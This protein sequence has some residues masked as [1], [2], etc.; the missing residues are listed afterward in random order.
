LEGFSFPETLGRWTDGRFA[1]LSMQ[2]NMTGLVSLAIE[3]RP[4]LPPG[5]GDFSFSVF[6][7]AGGSLSFT[8]PRADGWVSTITVQASALPLSARSGGTPAVLNDSGELAARR[9]L[10]VLVFELTDADCPKDMGLSTD[11]RRLGLLV[12]DIRPISHD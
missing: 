12:G 1:A 10:V 6:G 3:V 11:P 8:L 2:V 9:G 4:F 7:G 5:A